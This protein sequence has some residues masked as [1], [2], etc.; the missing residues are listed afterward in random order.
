MDVDEEIHKID[1]D[2]EDESKP[3]LDM[4]Y[5]FISY[6]KTRK[7]NK[8]KDIFEKDDPFPLTMFSKK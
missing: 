5:E 2:D 3:I 8:T 4:D 1:S 7:L 6:S